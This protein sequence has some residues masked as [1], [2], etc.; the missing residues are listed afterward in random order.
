MTNMIYSI[1]QH[2]LVKKGT[3]NYNILWRFVIL[4]DQKFSNLECDN[5]WNFQRIKHCE[6]ARAAALYPPKIQRVCV[7]PVTS[8]N[9]HFYPFAFTIAVLPEGITIPERA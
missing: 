4:F 1:H 9:S 6:H 5:S 8:L 3:E 7:F 2:S